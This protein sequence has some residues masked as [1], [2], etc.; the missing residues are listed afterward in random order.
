M[1][2]KT[3]HMAAYLLVWIGA[4]NWGLYG[5]F[6]FNLVMAI[7]GSWP[8]VEKL[9]YVLIGISGVYLFIKH[10]EYCKMCLEKK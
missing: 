10:K 1:D 9:I 8:M 5:L 7:F 4:L 6:N 2:K 3:L